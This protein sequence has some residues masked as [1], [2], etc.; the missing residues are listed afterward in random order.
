MAAGSFGLARLT[1]EGPGHPEGASA[2]ELRETS[3]TVLVGGIQVR[4]RGSILPQ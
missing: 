3:R 2:A 1:L 4:K